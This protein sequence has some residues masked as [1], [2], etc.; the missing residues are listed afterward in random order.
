MERRGMISS[1]SE[2]E[3][4]AEVLQT[5]M[6]ICVHKISTIFFSHYTRKHLAS[7]EEISFMELV[8]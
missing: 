8:N 3:K 7:Y 6:K 5:L 4:M 1:G 2:L